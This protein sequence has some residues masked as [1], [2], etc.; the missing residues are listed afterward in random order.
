MHHLHISIK[1]H[2]KNAL[3]CIYLIMLNHSV[4]FTMYFNRYFPTKNLEHRM[5]K[6]IK[7]VSVIDIY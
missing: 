7:G 2:K 3:N 4:K 6:Y 1:S 5:K